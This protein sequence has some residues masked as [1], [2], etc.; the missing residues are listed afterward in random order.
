M[1]VVGAEVVAL[2]MI[3]RM[4]PI[5]WLIFKD[6]VVIIV[7]I[8][9]ILSEDPSSKCFQVGTCWKINRGGGCLVGRVDK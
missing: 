3:V 5:I 8:W 6:V 2:M 1:V 4:W 7:R 9:L